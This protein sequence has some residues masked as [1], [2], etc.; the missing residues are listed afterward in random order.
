MDGFGP[1]FTAAVVAACEANVLEIGGAFSRTLDTTLLAAVGTPAAITDPLPLPLHGPGLVLPF[2]LEGQG[3]VLVLPESSGL[4]PAWYAA[5]DVTGASKLATLAQE[6]GMTL[7][8]DHITVTE[9][10]ATRVANLAAALQRAELA[11]DGT[12]LS[13]QLSAE[14]SQ[15]ACYLLWPLAKPAALPD[16]SP[17]LEN[18]AA[19][20]SAAAIKK[21]PTVVRPAA[22]AAPPREPATLETLPSFS[23]SMLRIKVPAMVTLAQQKQPVGKIIELLPGSII[24]FNKSCEEM[25]ELEVSGQPIALGECVKVGDK[26]GLRV[27]SLIMPGERFESVGKKKDRR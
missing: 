6:L 11:P 25:L 12:S 3:A 16:A 2:A 18:P 13:F 8:P 27:T 15:G 4:L 9:L 14:S 1:E 21:D 26:F 24:Q 7:F 17:A 10:P 5:P 19:P 23:R 22:A 20:K